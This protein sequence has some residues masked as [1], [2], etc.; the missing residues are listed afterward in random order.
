MWQ[1]MTSPFRQFS[2]PEPVYGTPVYIMAEELR[3]IA[4]FDFSSRPALAVQRDIFVFQCCVGWLGSTAWWQC[5]TRPQG[6]RSECRLA[7]VPA[8]IWHAEHFAVTC[9]SAWRILT[10][11]PQW[12]DT[13]KAARLCPIPWDWQGYKARCAEG[14]WS[15]M[16][17]SDL[18]LDLWRIKT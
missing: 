6:V 10:S 2:V 14:L 17:Y 4:D 13:R 3:Q 11:L 16:I 15:D 12:A 9:T 8:A 5:W 7:N 1:L 18:L